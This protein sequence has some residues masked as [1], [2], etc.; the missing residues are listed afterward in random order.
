VRSLEEIK[1]E[2]PERI[3]GCGLWEL[4]REEVIFRSDIDIAV[5]GS[6]R[7]KNLEVALW[8]LGKAPPLLRREGFRATPSFHLK[9][10]VVTRYVAVLGGSP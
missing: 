2:Q 7:E 8:L 10:K 6:S 5:T 9:A 3:L 1:K 4:G